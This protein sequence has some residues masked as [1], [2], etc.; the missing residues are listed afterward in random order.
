LADFE[1]TSVVGPLVA[2]LLDTP[3]GLRPTHFGYDEPHLPIKAA[4]EVAALVVGRKAVGQRMGGVSLGAGSIGYYQVRWAKL[5]RP[6]F[7]LVF[8]DF[9]RAALQS[10]PLRLDSLLRL[11]RQIVPIVHAVYAEIRDMSAPNS[12]VPVDLLTRLPEIPAVSVYGP[13]YVE[14]FGESK[15]LHAP[16]RRIER[17]TVGYYW[18]E[19]TDSI[20][21]P[22]TMDEAARIRQYLGE[23]AFMS[24]GK[25]LYRSGQAPNFDF[26]SLTP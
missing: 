3:L 23:T 16:F 14:M 6:V 24:G 1:A 5:H 8:G 9:E 10:A 22:P 20:F 25:R 7:S 19:A 15:L 21:E 13:P 2:T 4:D 12:E 17:L 18:L 11:I 26:S